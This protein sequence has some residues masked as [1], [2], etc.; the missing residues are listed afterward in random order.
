MA[1]TTVYMVKGDV[2]LSWVGN[3][4]QAYDE[5]VGKLPKGSL[6]RLTLRTEREKT[7]PQLKYWYAVILPVATEALLEAGYDTLWN[8]Q[9]GPVTVGRKTT[10]NSVD[11]AL[12]MMWAQHN[13][14]DDIP[15]K[16]NMDVEEMSKMTDFIIKWLGENLGVEVPEPRTDGQEIQS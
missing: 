1:K 16:A 15:S 14:E 11:E 3:W 5:Y 12:K 7:H 2:Q 13:G 8:A 10:L 4:Q 9:I 6:V